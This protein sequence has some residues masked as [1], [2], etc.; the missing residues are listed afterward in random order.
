[1]TAFRIV[2]S[3]AFATLAQFA[4]AYTADEQVAALKKSGVAHEVDLSFYVL[5]NM[6][7][8]VN[9][10][11]SYSLYVPYES[12][13]EA[14]QI[15]A[16][17]VGTVF[18][19]P[20]VHFVELDNR[21]ELEALGY[22][23]NGSG[24]GIDSDA[25]KKAILAKVGQPFAE[26][27]KSGGFQ[28]VGEKQNL[29][30]AKVEGV[31][32]F[33]ALENGQLLGIFKPIK[34]GVAVELKSTKIVSYQESK[35]DFGKVSSGLT[36]ENDT[37][38]LEVNT[39]Y[40]GAI[41]DIQFLKDLKDVSLA[42]LTAG[43]SKPLPAP[44]VN[45]GSAFKIGA[46][47]PTDVISKLTGINGISI[48]EVE[49]RANK[50]DGCSSG[51][52]L[53]AKGEDILKVMAEDNEK[54]KKMGLTHQQLALPLL[55]AVAFRERYGNEFTMNGVK[56]E[57]HTGPIPM[58]GSLPSPF[59]DEYFASIAFPRVTN[60]KTKKSVDFSDLHPYLINQ[61]GFYG[62]HQ[63]HSYVSPESI[64]EVF[65]DVKSAGQ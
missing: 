25:D 56:Y 64:I 26:Q 10:D 59:N 45:Q 9:S 17:S 48:S 7:V 55:K 38:R 49:A 46:M 19:S 12:F 21:G 16:V 53:L 23:T 29:Y 61:Y 22:T 65:G 5:G 2:L 8:F 57:I 30:A 37:K 40:D 42:E 14:A 39:H 36:V 32:V 58:C 41:S 11:G 6:G 31:T 33:A 35:D 34:E 62:S 20:G 1:M 63:N 43:L 18:N 28:A 3:L 60:M 15:K 27:L 52:P 54:V 24:G 50:V 13:L 51:E 47:N 4:H 44:K